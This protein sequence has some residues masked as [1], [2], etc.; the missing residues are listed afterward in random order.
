MDMR[1]YEFDTTGMSEEEQVVAFNAWSDYYN[2]GNDPDRSLREEARLQAAAKKLK[3][4][5]ID[6]GFQI[7]PNCNI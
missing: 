4:I 1:I 3:E 6:P 2:Y 5:G 7:V